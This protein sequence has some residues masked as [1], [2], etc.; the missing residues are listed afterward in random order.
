MSI[1]SRC[2]TYFRKRTTKSLEKDAVQTAENSADDFVLVVSIFFYSHSTIN[3]EIQASL[4][5]SHA[6]ELHLDIMFDAI[7]H[8]QVLSIRHSVRLNEV[9]RLLG[10]KLRVSRISSL[11]S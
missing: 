4:S 6:E 7:H 5:I 3:R 8:P 2:K 11:L 10:S 1:L 9:Q